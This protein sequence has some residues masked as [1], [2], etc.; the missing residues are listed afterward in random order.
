MRL[1]SSF[2]DF[3]YCAVV[4]ESVGYEL[5]DRP[6]RQKKDDDLTMGDYGRL[7][8]RAGLGAIT[9]V[10]RVGANEQRPEMR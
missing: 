8:N 3:F 1:L 5:S 6:V 2:Y 10:A 9:K 4:R 7:A